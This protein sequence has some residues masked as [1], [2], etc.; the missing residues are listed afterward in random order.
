MKHATFSSWPPVIAFARA[1]RAIRLRDTILTILVWAL[2]LY[3]LRDGIRLIV[4]YFSHPIFQLTRTHAVNWKEL[5]DDFKIFF[6]LSAVTMLWLVLWGLVHRRRLQLAAR[7]APRVPLSLARHAASF[8]FTAADIERWRTL[9]VAVVEFDEDHHVTNV[10]ARSAALVECESTN[11]ETQ[12]ENG[13][14]ISST[15]AVPEN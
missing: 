2:L 10:S 15:A 4:D 8:N 12:N 13:A 9:K 1:T 3:L 11:L 14:D 7:D 5:W 6:I